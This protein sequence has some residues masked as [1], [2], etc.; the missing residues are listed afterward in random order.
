MDVCCLGATNGA[1]WLWASLIAAPDA[2]PPDCVVTLSFL[3]RGFVSPAPN[4][5]LGGPGGHSLSGLYPL[6]CSAWAA[7]PGVQDSRRHS[8]KGH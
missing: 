8:S 3:Y 5:Q 1:H 2:A 6:T 4:P 7:L